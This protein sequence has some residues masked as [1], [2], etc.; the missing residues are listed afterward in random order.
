MNTTIRTMLALGSALLTL[1]LGNL[2]HPLLA[3]T[4][5]ATLQQIVGAVPHLNLIYLWPVM[6][7]AAGAA[8]LIASDPDFERTPALYASAAIV[9]LTCVGCFVLMAVWM[10]LTKQLGISP[11]ALVADPSVVLFM[12][13]MMAAVAGLP[14]WALQYGLVQ[15]VRGNRRVA[16]RRKVEHRQS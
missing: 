6:V 14:G 16:D 1:V 10:P 2:L 8:W 12:T 5:G 3:L 15:W 11:P 7:A 4:T 9:L 13:V